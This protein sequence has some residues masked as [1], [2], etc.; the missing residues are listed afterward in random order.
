MVVIFSKRG[1]VPAMATNFFTF[2]ATERRSSSWLG[3]LAVIGWVLSSQAQSPPVPTIEPG[4]EQA[5]RW[6]WSPESTPSTTWGLPLDALV[7]PNEE[8]ATG[9]PKSGKKILPQ[10]PPKTTL[11]YT[12]QKGDSLYV[13]ARQHGV[14]VDQVKVFNELKRD[15]INIG[16]VLRI[17][18]LADL[19]KMAPPPEPKPDKKAEVKPTKASP[20]Q[21]ERALLKRPLPSAASS[22]A[23]IVL[24][25]A[26]LDR[27]GFSAGPIDGTD[28]PLYDAALR[29]YDTAH[30]G[31]LTGQMGQVPEVLLAM[32]GAYTEYQLRFEDFRWI[33]PEPEAPKPKK[34]RKS[35]PAPAAPAPTITLDQL[36]SP[37]FLPYRSV[38]EF[39]A[40]RYHC[41][42]S[43]LRRINSGLKGPIQPGALF[44]VPNVL[45]FDLDE[46]LKEPLQPA[47]DPAQPITATIIANTRLEIRRSG[48]LIA[49]LPVSVAR[50][51]LRGR[52]TWTI[53]EALPRPKLTTS[54]DPNSPFPAPV[55]LP[56]GPNSPVG[57]IW[58]HLAKGNPPTLLPY[59][60][61]GT[62]IP[63]YMKKQESLGGFRLT[64][65]D[66]ARAV[67]LLPAN[68]PLKWE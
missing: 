68:T 19:Q 66:I 34:S 10:G 54:G 65:W 22:V 21:E 38:W 14:T 7:Q 41:S 24:T 9:D 11:E 55:T 35:T 33:K 48:K 29:S 15:I 58:I 46:A 59:G 23:R 62:S 61:H 60:L 2:A 64:N 30:P 52:G 20:Q 45:P 18:S 39:V 51:G 44:I 43:F 5:V 12:V 17:P 16:Q 47:A 37:A 40:E 42:E 26:Y 50:P 56:P 3:A 8:A 4:M 28:G 63:G 32:G 53:L 49:N 57:P 13:I 31:E 6:R 25:Q 27:Q 1:L 67:R 36:T